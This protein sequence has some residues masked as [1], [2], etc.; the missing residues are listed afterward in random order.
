MNRT[1]LF[2]LV[3]GL[4]VATLLH[5]S[6]PVT[7]QELSLMIRTGESPQEIM[8]DVS[9]RKLLKPL[10]A[11]EVEALQASGASPALLTALQ[12]A[13]LAAS[14]DQ[15]AAYRVHHLP[16]SQAASAPLQSA[17]QG[18]LPHPAAPAPL[19]AVVLP[20]RFTEGLEAAK[21]APEQS[22]RLNS[23]F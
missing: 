6:E 9:R 23:A 2:I 10:A 18:A 11:N 21:T 16:P 14:P 20:D 17:P 8:N 13:N 1:S 5:A 19:Q 22:V 12:N 7:F 3:L 4:G 15:I